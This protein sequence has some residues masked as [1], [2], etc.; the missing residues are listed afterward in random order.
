VDSTEMNL[1]MG[2]R[3]VDERVARERG[4]GELFLVLGHLPAFT[5]RRFC[6]SRRTLSTIIRARGREFAYF[7]EFGIGD[8]LNI[9]PCT[10]FDS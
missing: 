4:V 6:L 9:I 7:I 8:S 5:S 10:G 1:R 2:G 3:V